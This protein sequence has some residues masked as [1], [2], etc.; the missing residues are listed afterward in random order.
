MCVLYI[1]F[2]S[3]LFC[4]VFASSSHCNFLYLAGAAAAA[5]A[6]FHSVKNK[7]DEKKTKTIYNMNM[8]SLLDT[9]N[10]QTR[11]HERESEKKHNGFVDKAS[12]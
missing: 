4:S 6:D 11:M 5:A 10:E 12:N 7:R 1:F 8:E 9:T 3:V 2:L